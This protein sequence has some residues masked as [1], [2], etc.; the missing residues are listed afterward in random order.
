MLERKNKSVFSPHKLNSQNSKQIF[1][2]LNCK[3]LQSLTLLHFWTSVVNCFLRTEKRQCLDFCK[4]DLKYTFKKLSCDGNRTCSFSAGTESVKGRAVFGKCLGAM[5][6]KRWYNKGQFSHNDIFCNTYSYLF[7]L[8]G[9]FDRRTISFGLHKKILQIYHHAPIS[10][11]LGWMLQLLDVN[12]F[13]NPDVKFARPF[14]N[15]LPPIQAGSSHFGRST[16]MKAYSPAQ[17]VQWLNII[18]KLRTVVSEKFKWEFFLQAA[19]SGGWR[20]H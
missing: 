7:C 14:Y 3:N 4:V 19:A 13:A 17:T 9:Q 1:V 16:E 8:F 6:V 15:R 18:H 20:I 11:E 5:K 12:S 2:R 10:A